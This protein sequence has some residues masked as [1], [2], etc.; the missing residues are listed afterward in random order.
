MKTYNK[1]KLTWYQSPNYKHN[2]VLKFQDIW[3]IR[4]IIPIKDIRDKG[5]HIV[6]LKKLNIYKG[7]GT[8]HISV[9]VVLTIAHVWAWEGVL[10]NEVLHGYA[11]GK[12]IN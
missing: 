10:M 12:I 3:P 5:S 2:N 9:D 7:L 6:N 1:L 11:V 8:V 4:V